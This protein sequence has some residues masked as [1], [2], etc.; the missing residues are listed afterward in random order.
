MK[1]WILLLPLVV[2]S[3]GIAQPAQAV[4]PLCTGAVVIG[5][6]VSR[7]LG[8]D[9]SVT[10]LWIGALL[11]MLSLW[12]INW[13]KKKNIRWPLRKLTVWLVYIALIIGGLYFY[14]AFGHPLNKLWGFDKLALGIASG[15]I[16]ATLAL[17]IHSRLKIK[18]EGKSYFAMQRTIFNLIGLILATLAFYFLT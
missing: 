7:W 12:T 3:W 9:D 14:G 18:N 4:C 2:F 6:G 13:L 10:G 17:Q 8:I 15:I 11:I 5:L 1:K 16:V